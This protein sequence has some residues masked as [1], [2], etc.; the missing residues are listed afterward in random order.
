MT[1]VYHG[2]AGCGR[3]HVDNNK[4]I[5]FQDMEFCS[6]E[7]FMNSK[8]Y[9]EV[10]V[11]NDDYNELMEDF[12][13]SEDD[14]AT[15]EAVNKKIISSLEELLQSYDDKFEKGNQELDEILLKIDEIK[16]EGKI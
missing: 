8:Y 7:C 13:Q 4:K 9:E 16:T 5:T 11:S 10:V 1:N 3:I 14:K 2:C 15:F 12:K 6:I